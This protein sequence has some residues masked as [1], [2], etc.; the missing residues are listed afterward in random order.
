VT[1]NRTPDVK[2]ADYPVLDEVNE[3]KPQVSLVIVTYN[4]R[5]YIQACLESLRAHEHDGC[6]I[7]VVDNASSDGS[8]EF[9][10]ANF[11]DVRLIQAGDNLGFGGDNNLGAA[12]PQEKFWL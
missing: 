12:K 7:I 8:A 2:I 3:K 5:Q 4:A 6:E 10:A 11:P 9:I 1:D